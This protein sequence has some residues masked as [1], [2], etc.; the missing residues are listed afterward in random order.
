MPPRSKKQRTKLTLTSKFEYDPELVELK[1][2]EYNSN[3]D[4][5]PNWIFGNSVAKDQ[6]KV[7]VKA[8][9]KT[10]KVYYDSSLIWIRT[11][12]IFQEKDAKRGN[13]HFARLNNNRETLVV[14]DIYG[15]E[16]IEILGRARALFDKKKELLLK[17][18]IEEQRRKERLSKRKRR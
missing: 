18:T 4:I 7:E 13:M 5:H 12:R 16:V 3:D 10:T 15:K 1:V 11:D 14:E 8:Q 6:V 2:E 17:R 9:S